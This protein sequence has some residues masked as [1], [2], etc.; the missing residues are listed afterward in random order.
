MTG[1]ITL[2]AGSLFLIAA[3][4]LLMQIRAARARDAERKRFLA[5]LTLE[6]KTLPTAPV[7]QSRVM[8]LL[9]L[10]LVHRLRRAGWA[11]S[12]RQI[13]LL[14]LAFALAVILALAV[15]GWF[16]GILVGIVIPITALA[17]LEYRAQ[18]RMRLLSDCMLGFLE[19]L[20][21]LLSV[22]NSLS[23]A[24]VRAVENSPQIVGQYLTSTI[25]RIDN[26][27]GVAESLERCA[28]ELD[29][30]EL[31]LLATAART[32]LRFGG[33]MT[34]ILRNIVDNIRK[35]A[36]IERE[37]RADT[38]QIRSSAWVLALLPMFVATMVMFTN[39]SYARWFL[40]TEAGHKMIAYACISQLIGAWLM[41]LIT[42][43]R[44]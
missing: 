35:R 3:I 15:G 16:P 24:L 13:L 36:T 44:Y 20:R 42:R 25:R 1:T 30:Y 38:T 28:A 5:L 27:T 21:Q 22:G 29:I 14:G 19:R 18:R 12:E 2:A 6:S 31:H 32:N 40:V 7:A 26:G 41:R 8:A 43:T 37:L 11:P 10:A 33:S 9:P 23:N 39:T 34:Q 17:I 4:I